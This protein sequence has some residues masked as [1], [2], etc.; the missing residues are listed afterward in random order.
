MSGDYDQLL[1][2]VWDGLPEKVKAHER[3]ELP[4][5]DTLVEGN[6]TIIR[7]FSEI[8]GQLHRE[9]KYILMFL[10]KELAAPGQLSGNRAVIQRVLK[11]HLINEKIAAYAKEYVVC[12]ECARPD[13]KITA[14]SGQKI[15]KCEAC[16]G[17]WP[18]KRI[19]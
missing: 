13:T 14:L 11:R 9:P 8:A 16:G 4:Q 18:L 6:T 5:A 2:R 1:D 19:K 15:I 7:N 17:W 12:H 10:S 3:F